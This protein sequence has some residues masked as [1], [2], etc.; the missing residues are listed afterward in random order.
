MW[1]ESNLHN[2]KGV[3]N[4][5]KPHI[6]QNLL[7]KAQKMIDKEYAKKG[8]TEQILNKQ[9]KINKLMN[10]YDINDGEYKQ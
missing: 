4:N 5:M 10:K 1:T 8:L 9:I 2:N 6:L 7:E 3:K